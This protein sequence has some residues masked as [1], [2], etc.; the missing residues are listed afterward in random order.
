MAKSLVNSH[1]TISFDIEFIKI[2]KKDNYFVVA[3]LG[4]EYEITKS[5]SSLECSAFIY[6]QIEGVPSV[7]LVFYYNKLAIS[8]NKKI[9]INKLIQQTQSEL[10][11]ISII[12]KY[13]DLLF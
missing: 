2:Y 6:T 8:N 13:I 7:D 10:L 12:K 11:T 9:K 1:I 3:Q 5:K 4:E